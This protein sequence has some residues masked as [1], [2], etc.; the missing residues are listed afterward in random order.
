[1]AGVDLRA[2]IAQGEHKTYTGTF[3]CDPKF[4]P[5]WLYEETQPCV[6]YGAYR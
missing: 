6:R 5:A 3:L 4:L 1:L 2:A